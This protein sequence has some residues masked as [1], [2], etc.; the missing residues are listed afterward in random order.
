[1]RQTSLAQP[2]RFVMRSVGPGG[3]GGGG[4][5]RARLRRLF[6]I[7]TS[8][9]EVLRI[10]LAVR[11]RARREQ[12]VANRLRRVENR[13]MEYMRSLFGAFCADEEKV[14]ARCMLAF[15]VW[16]G[17]HFIAADHGARGRAEVRKLVLRRLEA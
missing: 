14:E 13:R 11:D 12:A 7:G 17:D 5:P 15:C 10:D 6:A 1:M 9:D 3:L 2:V 4:D 16:I 8:S